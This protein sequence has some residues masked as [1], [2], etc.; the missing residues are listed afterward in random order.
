MT[1]QQLGPV[2]Q[3][4]SDEKHWCKG[5]RRKREEDGTLQTCFMGAIELE[6]PVYDRQD[7]AYTKVRSALDSEWDSVSDFNDHPSTTHADIMEV[8]RIT[9]V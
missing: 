4:L 6:Y 8:C 2:G 5:A 7:E 3:W 1:N 9:G